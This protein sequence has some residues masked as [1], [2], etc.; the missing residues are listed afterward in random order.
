MDFSFLYVTKSVFKDMH[1]QFRHM[2][3]Q[4]RKKAGL[5]Q[6][7][8]AELLLRPQSFVSKVERGE[9]RLDVIEFFEVAER[10]GFDPFAFLRALKK[11]GEKH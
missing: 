6:V 7:Q 11:A 10:I 5:T 8:L 2:L 9:R 3:V 4:A 1:E